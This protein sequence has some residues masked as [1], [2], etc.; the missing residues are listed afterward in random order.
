MKGINESFDEIR[1]TQEE[2]MELADRLRWA[3]EQEKTMTEGTKRKAKKVSRGVV[4]GIAAALTLTA[5]TLAAALSTGLRGYF[6]T[7]TP[8]AQEKLESGIYQLN[9]S[10][11]Y[12]GWTV[13]LTDCVGDDNK[14]FIWVEVTAPEDVSLT[15]SEN[16]WFR[17]LFDLSGEGIVG[18]MGGSLY[19]IP[20]GDPEDN[21]LSFC[22]EASPWVDEGLR[23]AVMDIT[24]DPIE[25]VA[26]AGGENYQE[27][28]MYERTEAIRDH[29]WLFEDVVLDYPDQAI[30]LEPGLEV[31]YLDGTTTLSQVTISPLTVT[32]RVEGGS[33]Y[34]YDS[35]IAKMLEAEA[36]AENLSPDEKVIE[37]P[38]GTTI[39]F[40]SGDGAANRLEN[41]QERSDLLWGSLGVEVHM[42][43][44][45][46]FS[47]LPK[48][49][50]CSGDNGLPP[51]TPEE[52]YVEGVFHYKEMN[53][54][55][56]PDRVIDPSQV[57]YVTVC[58]VNIPV[59][60]E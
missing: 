13:A 37:T 35:R 18:P 59:N 27:I 51:S 41:A 16:R 56:I 57:D 44:G 49:S 55:L 7:A 46:V 31:D 22:I 29:S 52:A 39:T 21:R 30:R 10:L 40:G 58:G 26:L 60:G 50:G 32:V 12:N 2:Q 33:C 14:A 17:T 38:S 6:D 43:D 5:G 45:T 15:E 3:A 42:K 4:I 36:E 48:A 9:R 34:D 24:L 25:D 28:E 53:H 47:Q 19:T 23:G 1:F 54:N 20:D 8:G 11:E